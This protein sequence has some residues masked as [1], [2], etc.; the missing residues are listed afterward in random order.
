MVHQR[1]GQAGK[2][3][4]PMLLATA[5]CFHS[6]AGT[7]NG[8]FTPVAAGS[9]VNL[10]TLGKRDWIQWGLGGDYKVNRKAGI[11]PLISNFTLI[12]QNN[13]ANPLSFSAPYWFE[14][15]DSSFCS[16]SDGDPVVGITSNYPR[17]LAYSYPVLG[18]S[19]FRITVPAGT[20]TNTLS[21]FVG[22]L[23]GRG[24]F[25]ATL[26]GQPNYVHSPLETNVNGVY[27]INYAANAPGQTL[28]IEWTLSF[29]ASNGNVTLQAAAL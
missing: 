13:P 11:T 5:C 3:M 2:G 19:G 23:S 17:V 25:K 16:W 18:G 27:T 21:V 12:S 7:I 8:S 1:T 9:N 4:L 14:A 26:S 15:L 20:T 28:T 6:I 10:T 24:Q 29:M 22:T